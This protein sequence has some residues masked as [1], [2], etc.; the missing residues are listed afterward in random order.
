MADLDPID[1]WYSELLDVHV[2]SHHPE[3]RELT[4]G[5]YDELGISRRLPKHHSKPAQ[6]LDRFWDHLSYLCNQQTT[7][8]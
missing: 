7:N 6:D 3:I 5:L 2:W 4:N 1:R 8:K